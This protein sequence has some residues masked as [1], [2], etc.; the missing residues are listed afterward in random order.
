VNDIEAPLSISCPESIYQEDPIVEYSIPVFTDNCAFTIVLAEGEESGNVFPHGTTTVIY[1]AIDAAGNTT[2]CVF[3]VT[4]NLPP[5][6]EDDNAEFD[7]DDSEI[8]IDVIDNDTDP[9]GDPLTVT[10]VT[11]GS[12]QA[13]IDQDGNISYVNNPEDFCGMD[14]LTYV[15]CDNFGACDTAQIFINV[16]CPIGLIIPEAFSPNG[17]GVNDN[18]VILGLDDYPNN[19]LSIFNRYGHKVFEAN[20]YLNDWD[21]TSESGLTIGSGVLTKGTYFYILDLGNGE[22]IIKGFF[23]LNK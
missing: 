16:E 3:T 1:Q 8:V 2:E 23:Y 4:I 9:D 20:N 21:G 22:K 7:E 11:S 14:T 13:S 12:G 15:V 18:L 6:A 19:N 5:D 10:N 17:D